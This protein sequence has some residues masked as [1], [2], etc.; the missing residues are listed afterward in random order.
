MESTLG[1]IREIMAF[2]C[3]FINVLSPAKTVDA[4]ARALSWTPYWVPVA[5]LPPSSCPP[6]H[7]P[8]LVTLLD[9]HPIHPHTISVI[10]ISS[11]CWLQ[12]NLIIL[13][14]RWS[15]SHHPDI[16]YKMFQL[17]PAEQKQHHQTC[18]PHQSCIR[19]PDYHLGQQPWI[20]LSTYHRNVD[21]SMI[22]LFWFSSS[23][24]SPWSATLDRLV[25][26]CHLQVRPAQLTWKS[27]REAFPCTAIWQSLCSGGIKL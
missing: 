19:S 15:L 27:K 14:S 10:H 8:P 2:S 5:T 3:L 7:S 20:V 1:L 12:Y 9:P 6:D 25:N 4:G 16:R 26:F 13:I 17:V 11:E 22:W 23:S 21:C 18:G 24:S